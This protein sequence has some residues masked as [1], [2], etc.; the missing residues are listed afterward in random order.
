M[1]AQEGAHFATGGT[2]GT[3]EGLERCSLGGVEVQGN[4][5]RHDRFVEGHSNLAR[6]PAR[7]VRVPAKARNFHPF[8]GIFRVEIEISRRI[9]ASSMWISGDP[10]SFRS[11]LCGI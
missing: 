1:I 7:Y 2:P 10:A 4:E 9:S 5:C 8:P 6:F 11:L 3:G